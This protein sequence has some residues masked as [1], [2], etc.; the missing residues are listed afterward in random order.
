MA[1]PEGVEYV[2]TPIETAPLNQPVTGPATSCGLAY[3]VYYGAQPFAQ[4]QDVLVSLESLVI[5][6]SAVVGA[7]TGVNAMAEAVGNGGSVSLMLEG[8]RESTLRCR[9][10]FER[11]VGRRQD[12]DGI[13]CR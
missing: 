3:A 4:R 8:A 5:A 12:G 7:C 2:A 11:L 10:R 9:D 6:T 1:F 13:A